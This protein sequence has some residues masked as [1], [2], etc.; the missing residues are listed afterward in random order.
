MLSFDLLSHHVGFQAAHVDVYRSSSSLIVS[1][2]LSHARDK[3]EYAKPE[4]QVAKDACFH[5][6]KKTADPKHCFDAHVLCWSRFANDSVIL[7]ALK[8]LD[9]NC[10]G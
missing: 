8:T 5:L 3:P 6:D 1:H 10:S 9:N 7:G 4:W 2:F